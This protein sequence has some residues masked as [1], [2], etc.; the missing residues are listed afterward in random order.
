[1]IHGL[2]NGISWLDKFHLK[3]DWTDGWVAVT[4]GEMDEI[5]AHVATGTPIEI[6]P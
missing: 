1:M 3:R 6:L 4:S 2:P 5:W